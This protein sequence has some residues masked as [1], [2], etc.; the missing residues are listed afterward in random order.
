VLE[1]AALANVMDCCQANAVGPRLERDVPQPELL[2]AA[3]V[4]E[5]DIDAICSA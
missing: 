3:F 2:D 5:A 4:A 1:G